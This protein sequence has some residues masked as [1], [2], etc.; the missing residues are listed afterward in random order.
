MV[1]DE[2]LKADKA[3]VETIGDEAEQT[4]HRGPIEAIGREPDFFEAEQR[5]R[6]HESQHQFEPKK[7]GLVAGFNDL[8]KHPT[9]EIIFET[10]QG[11][12]PESHQQRSTQLNQ[13]RKFEMTSEGLGALRRLEDGH[14][15]TYRN[16][17]AEKEERQRGRIPE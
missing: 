12:D 5:N 11:I 14:C 8:P 6:D 17:R 13:D 1:S 4:D 15:Q 10:K 9:M 3:D 2:S 7:I 16:R